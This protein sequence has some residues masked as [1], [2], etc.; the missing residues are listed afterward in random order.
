MKFVSH[1]RQH[2]RPLGVPKHNS[3]SIW[4]HLVTLVGLLA[5]VEWRFVD[6][7]MPRAPCNA[8]IS[9]LGSS[10]GSLPYQVSETPNGGDG[11]R[12]PNAW[13]VPIVFTPEPFTDTR[14]VVAYLSEWAGSDPRN[15]EYVDALAVSKS[16]QAR[17]ACAR[18][19][20]L[21][22]LSARAPP[23]LC[24]SATAAVDRDA[25]VA[26]RRTPLAAE[27]LALQRLGQLPEVLPAPPAAPRR[28]DAGRRRVRHQLGQLRAPGVGGWRLL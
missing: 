21:G 2:E 8:P 3:A 28:S 19:P 6:G 13:R 12:L 27:A 15:I 11:R 25:P 14:G 5:G 1:K 4:G 26:G 22:P 23:T 17:S 16:T 7:P 18:H 9:T 10:Q 24:L 20:P